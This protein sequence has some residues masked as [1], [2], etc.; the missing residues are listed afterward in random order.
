MKTINI[1]EKGK[2]CDR[3]KQIRENI[4]RSRYIPYMANI[5]SVPGV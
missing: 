4:K 5:F 2:A 3:K 1:E